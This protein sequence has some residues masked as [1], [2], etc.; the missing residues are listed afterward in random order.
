MILGF[1]MSSLEQEEADAVAT[2]VVGIAKLVLSGM[3][4]DEEVSI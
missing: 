3:V 4:T 1:L 2:S